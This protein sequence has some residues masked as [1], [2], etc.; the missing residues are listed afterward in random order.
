MVT[1][2]RD[3][4][5]TLKIGGHRYGFSDWSWNGFDTSGTNSRIELGPLG[6]RRIPVS[7][8]TGVS[9]LIGTTLLAAIL[10]AFV[11]IRRKKSP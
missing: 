3:V 6:V 8:T 1:S 5:Y 4:D 10:L 2:Q 9:I 7:A 11:L